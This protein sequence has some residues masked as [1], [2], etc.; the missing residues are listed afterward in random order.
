MD[1]YAII[2]TLTDWVVA[3]ARSVE[4]LNPTVAFALGAFT[5]F[6]VD[7]VLQRI[8]SWMKWAILLGVLA[9]LGLSI[10]ELTSMLRDNDVEQPSIALPDLG[11]E[12]PTAE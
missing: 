7:K 4:G 9:A 6:L 12:I 5:W 3:V 11:M 8:M 10:P 2:S 1:F